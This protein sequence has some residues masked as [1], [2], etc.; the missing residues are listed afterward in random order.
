MTEDRDRL[1]VACGA[2]DQNLT[3]FGSCTRA[4]LALGSD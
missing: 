1:G 3:Y 2:V 4:L